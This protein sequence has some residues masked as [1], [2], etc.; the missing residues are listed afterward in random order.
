M[1]I[2]HIESKIQYGGYFAFVVRRRDN[3]KIIITEQHMDEFF[4]KTKLQYYE[5]IIERV[6]KSNKLN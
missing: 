4:P 6:T 5:R 1:L 3:S 2:S